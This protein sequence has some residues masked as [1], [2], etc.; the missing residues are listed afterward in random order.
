MVQGILDHSYEDRGDA[1]VHEPG[2]TLDVETALA[3]LWCE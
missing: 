1:T 3:G 2:A